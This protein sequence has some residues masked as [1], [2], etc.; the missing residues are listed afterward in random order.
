VSAIPSRRVLEEPRAR[1]EE[2]TKEREEEG[3]AEKRRE[4][5]LSAGGDQSVYAFSPSTSSGGSAAAGK[6]ISPP[7]IVSS[8]P[9]RS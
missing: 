2:A 9:P 1:H 3:N 7:G 4:N 6:A 8:R 5:F